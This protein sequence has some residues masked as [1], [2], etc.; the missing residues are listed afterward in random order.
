MAWNYKKLWKIL[1]DMDLTKTKFAQL[2]D[3]SPPTL[4]KLNKG[5]PVSMDILEKI[6]KTLE[7]GVGD[8]VEY[9]PESKQ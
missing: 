3:I 9:V 6:C 4:A 8:I 5:E 1:I 2:A 7:C